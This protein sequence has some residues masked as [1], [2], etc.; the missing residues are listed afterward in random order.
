[1]R[2]SR[3]T[4]AAVLVASAI[5]LLLPS[6][7]IAAEHGDGEKEQARKKS[8][9][10]SMRCPVCR[11][12]MERMKTLDEL[13]EALT[14]AAGAADAE[15]A[16]TTARKIAQARKMLKHQKQMLHEQMK[17][18]MKKMHGEMPGHMKEM[19]D[20]M[21]RHKKEMAEHMQRMR[22]CREQHVREM[23]RCMADMNKCMMGADGEKE[24]RGE[25]E[26]RE[27]KKGKGDWEKEKGEWKKQ[28]GERE[29]KGETC[30]VVNDRCPM[31]G[32]RLDRTACPTKRTCMFHGRRVG[33]CCAGCRGKW[34]KLDDDARW[35]KFNAA[36]GERERKRREDRERG[37]EYEHDE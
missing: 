35:K 9:K 21:A 14:E 26:R 16:A 18:H 6:S 15:D 37:R 19:R 4:L 28:K 12:H 36:C 20:K 22:R 30:E 34:D 27:W 1:M 5:G 23:E 31:D 7:A 8:E 33:F 32:K 13:N 11:M 25:R 29:D 10:P 17:R 2:T 3:Y 24:A